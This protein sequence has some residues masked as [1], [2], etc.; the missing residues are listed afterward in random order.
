MKLKDTTTQAFSFFAA[1]LAGFLAAKGYF[2]LA[3]I[4]AFLSLL[5]G[6]IAL[7]KAAIQERDGE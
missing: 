3:F 6:G 5:L 1:I 7:A 4:S 2:V